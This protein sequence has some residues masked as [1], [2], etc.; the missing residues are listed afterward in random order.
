MHEHVTFLRPQAHSTD[1]R[2]I[3]S[4]FPPEVLEQI[5]GRV[6]LLALLLLVAFAFDL[7]IYAGNWAAV[8]AGYPLPSSFFE[9]WA[10]Q[11]VNV[12]AV[13]ASAGLWWVA[14]RRH[15]SPSRLHTLGLAYEIAI[16]FIIAMLTFWQY[17]RRPPDAAESHMGSR[18]DHLVPVDPA[19]PSGPHARRRDRGWGDV[20]V[21][22]SS[23]RSHWQ[24][25]SRS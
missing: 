22:A 9:T 12:T 2:G 6:R 24:G 14:R 25:D 8:L 10:F 4:V 21:G 19:G 11:L 17:L 23:A 18:G 16:C 20:S 13:A 7:V 1:A 3:T 15:V 5:R